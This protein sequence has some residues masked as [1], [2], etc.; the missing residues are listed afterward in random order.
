MESLERSGAQDFLQQTRALSRRIATQQA[1]QVIW[2]SGLVMLIIDKVQLLPQS[3]D[4]HHSTHGK[5][6]PSY[7]QR[8][9]ADVEAAI[10]NQR[11]HSNANSSRL[12]SFEACETFLAV[13]T[14]GCVL[15]VP[16]QKLFSGRRRWWQL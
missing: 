2:S 7:P 11:Q 8:R 9:R 1:T 16:I 15:L 13:H 10:Y 6:L 4:D 12:P 5:D 14:V 3:I